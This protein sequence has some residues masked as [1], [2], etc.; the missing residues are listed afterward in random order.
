MSGRVSESPGPNNGSANNDARLLSQL[1]GYERQAKLH[2]EMRCV[3]DVLR[4]QCD[5]AFCTSKEELDRF[6]SALERPYTRVLQASLAVFQSDIQCAVEKGVLD[7]SWHGAV[8]PVVDLY[9]Q[10]LRRHRKSSA[11][12]QQQVAQSEG[13]GEQ[14]A[15]LLAN[16]KKRFSD[17]LRKSLSL[18]TSIDVLLSGAANSSHPGRERLSINDGAKACGERG[19][20]K[21]YLGDLY[22]YQW[23]HG[24]G[25]E[26]T[27]CKALDLYRW[28]GRISPHNGKLYHVI[29]V[30]YRPKSLLL[31]F[32]YDCR[33]LNVN[34]P[35]MSSR[36]CMLAC[37]S[38][39]EQQLRKKL[40]IEKASMLEISPEK[41]ARGQPAGEAAWIKNVLPDGVGDSE[42][43][44]V[45][46]LVCLH[47]H[48]MLF[49]KIGLDQL[50]QWLH[51]AYLPVLI[52]RIGR[53][54]SS[55][56][57]TRVAILDLTALHMYS[58]SGSNYASDAVSV[59]SQ[60]AIRA[61][62]ATL[63]VC[64]GVIMDKTRV[65]AEDSGEL[66]FALSYMA[67]IMQVSLYPTTERQQLQQSLGDALCQGTGK[68]TT[69]LSAL[70][71]SFNRLLLLSTHV[72][73]GSPN[74][75]RHTPLPE[76]LALYGNRWIRPFGVCEDSPC[77]GD[78]VVT[79]AGERDTEQRVARVLMLAEEM[80]AHSKWPQL[81]IRDGVFDT[82]SGAIQSF[83]RGDCSDL[84]ESKMANVSL[85]NTQQQLQPTQQRNHLPRHGDRRSGRNTHGESPLSLLVPGSK[86]IF[87]T[88]CYLNDLRLIASVMERGWRVVVPLAVLQE[89]RGLTGGPAEKNRLAAMAV[90]LIEARFDGWGPTGSLLPALSLDV[91]TSSGSTVYSLGIVSEVFALSKSMDDV[92][93][94]TSRSVDGALKKGSPHGQRMPCAVLVTDDR[95]MRIKAAMVCERG[96]AVV[97]MRQVRAFIGSSTN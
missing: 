81:Q 27:W 55:R 58:K 26:N 3:D 46:Q 49:T 35:F 50:D 23:L 85:S 14:T 8:Y 53:S 17:F 94:D 66:D 84:L 11:A 80:A 38:T 48:S 7:R 21:E 25:S 13:E 19:K 42:L 32:Y 52:A 62:A 86:F 37:L 63:D 40:G 90:K 36:E 68:P 67:V 56:F 1:E 34:R 41:E 5:S 93:I 57:G 74:D 97:D 51:S 4:Q 45:W 33:S 16:T 73:A 47:L 72:I 6:W 20:L 89:L 12:L 2:G 65:P 54:S 87:D 91:C 31:S 70:A 83:D 78:L 59:E 44:L 18:Y 39:S 82:G 96:L 30:L 22:R 29:S 71:R 24:L 79:R 95:N 28:G 77:E 88:N 76:D 64:A 92:I 61:I 10:V 75:Y 15:S 60:C 69:V 43:D 9:R